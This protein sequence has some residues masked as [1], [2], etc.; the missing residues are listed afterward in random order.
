MRHDN[1]SYQVIY[2]LGLQVK[3]ELFNFEYSKTAQ[4]SK[5]KLLFKTILK[6]NCDA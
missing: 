3:S 5:R 1:G 6:V 4:T 2:G